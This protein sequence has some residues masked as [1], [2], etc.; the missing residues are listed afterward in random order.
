MKRANVLRLVAILAVVVL[1]SMTTGCQKASVSL[2]VVLDEQ[3]YVE[4]DDLTGTATVV[5]T[6]LAK[7]GTYD[8]LT[9]EFLDTGSPPNVKGTVKATGVGVIIM[10]WDNEPKDI[11]L[12]NLGLTVPENTAGAANARFTLT[13]DGLGL[14]PISDTVICIVSEPQE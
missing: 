7:A 5:A 11:I 8:T 1:A 3:N 2:D 13:G 6:G 12:G 14:T 9:V 4:G 10:P